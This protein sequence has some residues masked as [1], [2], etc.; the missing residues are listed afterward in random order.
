MPHYLFVQVM[1]V[2]GLLAILVA[3]ASIPVGARFGARAGTLVLQGSLF[4][5]LALFTGCLVWGA[6]TG[7]LRAFNAA[8]EPGAMLQMGAFFAI[9]YSMTYRFAA[10]Y[11]R[12]KAGEAND[13]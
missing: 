12:D 10:S 1:A 5:T 6:A 4:G 3:G 7:D 9:M 13:A 11:L 8:A 2:A